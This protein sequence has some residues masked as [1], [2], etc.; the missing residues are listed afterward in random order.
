M[1]ELI[2][3]QL[4]DTESST[5]TYLL[6]DPK[7]RAGVL[8]DP[9]LERVA[10]DLKTLQE[11]DVKLKFILETHVHADHITGADALRAAT[12]AKVG[13]GAKS[14]VDCADFLLADGEKLKVDGFEITALSTPGHTAGCT[15]YFTSGMVFTGDALFI[16]GTGRT[17]FQDG[18]P[19]RL[20]ESIHKKLFLL[21]ND[22]FVYPAHDYNGQT[23]S[24][25]LEE[26][27]FNP[28]AKT[29]ISKDEFIGI[30][31]GLKLSDP[32]KIHEAVP[33][34]LKCGRSEAAR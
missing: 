34:N 2:F 12:G 27:A 33:A 18:S 3:R 32:K 25:I 24:T 23:R 13:I 8:I 16:R 5:Y 31:K 15:S 19:E 28:R 30:L 7:T 4:F 17:D 14:G 11:L 9:V 26:K 21:P 22:T 6:A 29:S 1:A 20:Y 10:R